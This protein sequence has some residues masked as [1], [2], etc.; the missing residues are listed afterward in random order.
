MKLSV[1]IQKI[2]RL[3][4][5]CVLPATNGRSSSLVQVSSESLSVTEHDPYN[6]V[7]WS[8]VYTVVEPPAAAARLTPA[9]R[10]QGFIA[11]RGPCGRSL[12]RV[13]ACHAVIAATN[14]TVAINPSWL[15][16]AFLRV[17][18]LAL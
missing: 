13:D 18:T 4:T 8:T 1:A 11:F 15:P 6:E 12:P 2:H 5:S 14:K 9:V 16:A 17:L 3:V 10:H 7:T